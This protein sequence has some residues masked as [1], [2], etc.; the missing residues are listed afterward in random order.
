[1]GPSYLYNFFCPKAKNNMFD[2]FPN[3]K[4]KRNSKS[5]KYL[6]Q[7]DDFLHE[8]S[9]GNPL[10]PTCKKNGV[11]G[12]KMDIINFFKFFKIYGKRFKKSQNEKKSLIDVLW[13]DYSLR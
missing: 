7:I 9:W 11:N 2:I 8:Y 12:E 6:N 13:H 1:M 10:P 4:K 5:S 3:L